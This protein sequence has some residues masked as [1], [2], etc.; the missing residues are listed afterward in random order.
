MP[1]ALLTLY[2]VDGTHLLALK[3]KRRL[4][5][6]VKVCRGLEPLSHADLPEDAVI[7][8][9]SMPAAFWWNI[10]YIFEAVDPI[11]NRYFAKYHRYYAKTIKTATPEQCFYWEPHQVSF[12]ISSLCRLV[13]SILNVLPPGKTDT[14]YGVR[15]F[16]QVMRMAY[17]SRGNVEKTSCRPVH[18][19]HLHHA[20]A[21]ISSYIKDAFERTPGTFPRG[22]NA[23]LIDALLD[24][25]EKAGRFFQ[26]AFITEGEAGFY[27]D[28]RGIIGVIEG[29]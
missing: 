1:V 21:L 13:A 27:L 5:R 8:S 22:W 19:H 23:P 3:K 10:D 7:K 25:H 6:L 4:R 9:V 26:D 15:W 14:T 16:N 24:A 20:F 17:L 29:S 2:S 12:T 18:T 28:K 11:D